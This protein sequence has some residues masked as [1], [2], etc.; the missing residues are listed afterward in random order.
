MRKFLA[1]IFT[2][3][4]LVIGAGILGIPY[5]VVRAGFW[6]GML[7][8]IIVALALLLMNLMIGEIALRTDGNH[9]LPGFAERYLG[10]KGKYLMLATTAFACYSA[11]VAY[12]LGV[13]ESLSVVFGGSQ[14]IWAVIFYAAMA[15]LIYG[16]INVLAGSETLLEIIQFVILSAV[17]YLAFNSPLFSTAT[18]SGFSVT[19]LLGPVGV[20]L[21]AFSGLTAV[22]LMKDI[23]KDD[24]KRLKL[25]IICG[26]IIVASVYILF[27]AAVIGI[28]GADTTE[29]ATTG[30]SRALGQWSGVLVSG[31]AILAMTTSF[32]ALGFV[33]KEMY[34]EDFRL[35]ENQSWLL[36]MAVAPIVL[37]LGAKSFTLT[38]DIGGS[39]SVGVAGIMVLMMHK[40]IRKLKTRTPEYALKL[41][42]VVY[43]VLGALFIVAVANSLYSLF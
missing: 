19:R 6:T 9:Q 21:F 30:L 20:V 1:A 5:V 26:K 36:T 11:L 27:A 39:I 37:F 34:L 12:T 17:F 35:S 42:R 16:G 24:V 2:L 25:A 28:T 7:T 43:Y 32:I 4:G 13:S 14:H 23:L 22:P 15:L 40:K 3:T 10:R 38:L 41:P 29:V 18:L 31:F 8:I 33:L